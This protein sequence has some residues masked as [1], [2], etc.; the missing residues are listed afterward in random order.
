MQSDIPPKIARLIGDFWAVAELTNY[1]EHEL[2]RRIVAR[3]GLLKIDA[4]S[5]LI[6]VYKNNLRSRYHGH[7][8]MSELE[9]LVA[10]LRIDH[11]K[12]IRAIRHSL[13]GHSLH[14]SPEQIEEGWLFP[15]KSSYDILSSDLIEID[16]ALCSIDAT[17]YLGSEGVLPIPGDVKNS[18][19][20]P[21]LLGDPE[22]IRAVLVYAGIWSPGVTSI[23]PGNTTVQDVSLRVAGLMTYLLQVYRLTLPI[24]FN[25]RPA[26]YRR[27]LYELLVSDLVALKEAIYVGPPSN[28]YG[29]TTTS[30][31]DEWRQNF[32]NH[33]GVQEL[34]DFHAQIPVE[35]SGW[36]EDLRNKVIAHVDMGI[37][38][39][40]MEMNNW[41]INL[42]QFM[43]F[44]ECFSNAIFAAARH[45]IATSALFVPP[46]PLNNVLGLARN[47][48][49]LFWNDLDR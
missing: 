42:R 35:F 17:D 9:P 32:P 34:Q 11:D 20:Q 29:A 24:P 4:L 14:L 18:W 12:G 22:Q 27:L 25:F 47:D 15:K 38:I 7:A 39:E 5:N 40:S 21:E 37:P 48:D 45:D 13:V 23:V 36:K 16:K 49:P 46:T 8:T 31:L 2:E 43:D 33:Q 30:M 26:I 28:K 10:R 3:L 41:P 1:I 6:L 44:V 19:R